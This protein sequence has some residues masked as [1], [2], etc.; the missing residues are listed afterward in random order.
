MECK[1]CGFDEG[2]SIENGGEKF[3]GIFSM[4][5]SFSTTDEKLCGIYGCPCCGSV[6]FT[7]DFQYIK[8]R[9]VEY[10]NKMRRN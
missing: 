7:T 2:L 1:V 4:G 9:K 5:K 6:I 10:V 3:I 8:A